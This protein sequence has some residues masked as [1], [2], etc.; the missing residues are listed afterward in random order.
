MY[1]TSLNLSPYM[2]YICMYNCTCTC[3]VPDTIMFTYY[4]CTTVYFVSEVQCTSNVLHSITR[5]LV[6]WYITY[7]IT[8]ITVLSTL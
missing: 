8:M 2:M 7:N 5:S 1:H 6:L 4:D 3:T